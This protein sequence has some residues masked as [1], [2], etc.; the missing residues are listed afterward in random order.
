MIIPEVVV[1]QKMEEQKETQA[2]WEKIFNRRGQRIYI[3][4][5]HFINSGNINGHNKKN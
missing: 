3:L 5:D 2:S 1:F 4:G